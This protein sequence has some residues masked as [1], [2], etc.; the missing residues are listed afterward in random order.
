M[1][2][3]RTNSEAV[4]F[5]TAIRGAFTS[6]ERVAPVLP[7]GWRTLTD[8]RKMKSVKNLGDRFNLTDGAGLSAGIV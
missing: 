2:R 4:C 5:R 6:A 8:R 7:E 1:P 3:N